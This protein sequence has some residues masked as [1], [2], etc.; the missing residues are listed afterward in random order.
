MHP[1][2]WTPIP[3]CSSR[4]CCCPTYKEPAAEYG[5]ISRDQTVM[6]KF[7]LTGI[8]TNS[9]H[10]FAFS[11]SRAMTQ[12]S[13]PKAY[14][15]FYPVAEKHAYYMEQES[16]RVGK[17][18]SSYHKT[19]GCTDHVPYRNTQNS[20]LHE[21]IILQA[22]TPSPEQMCKPSQEP[23]YDAKRITA[24]TPWPM[25]QCVKAKVMSF[26]SLLTTKLVISTTNL[27]KLGC[28]CFRECC[29]HNGRVSII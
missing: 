22:G 8:D 20:R 29:Y 3:L 21:V 24:E 10:R 1:K 17:K 2:P 12:Y 25:N 6:W 14:G 28:C 13:Q 15:V 19:M 7:I 18:D 26:L 27:C 5:N 11:A 4:Q 16:H 9:R 23:S